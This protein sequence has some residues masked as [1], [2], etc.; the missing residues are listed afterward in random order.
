MNKL[1]RVK[2]VKA[3]WLPPTAHGWRY[4]WAKANSMKGPTFIYPLQRNRTCQTNS[5]F[6]QKMKAGYK[7]NK[8]VVC[9]SSRRQ[10][11]GSICSWGFSSLNFGNNIAN[12][13]VFFFFLAIKKMDVKN[14][15]M[16]SPLEINNNTECCTS[17]ALFAG[18]GDKQ[19]TLS[20]WK[21]L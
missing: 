12:Y 17:R 1:I 20:W 9:N 11:I 13:R 7:M 19:T 2:R 4:P 10:H 5:Y 16:S 3:I 18:Q 15:F 8:R 14:S 6:W 21:W